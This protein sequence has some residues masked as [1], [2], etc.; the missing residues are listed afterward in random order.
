MRLLI[1]TLYGAFESIGAYS[2]SKVSSRREVFETVAKSAI[3]GFGSASFVSV[4][5]AQAL[6]LCPPKANNCVRTT[7]TPP[8]GMSDD[9]IVKEVRDTINSYP[10]E[11]QSDVDGGGWIITS[12]NLLE[13][14]LV[15]IEYRSSGKGNF[16]KFFN[17][18]KPFVDDLKLEF[19]DGK[20][21]V[22][23][24]SRVGDSDFGVNKK[25]VDYLAASLAANGWSI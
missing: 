24:Q 6:E 14:G 12:D 17:G 3:V 10:Q 11:G 21:E 25:R 5:S 13:S 22:K 7:W 20:I 1:L 15:T 19:K 23:S 9:E 18:G 16:A 2:L 4:S 8:S